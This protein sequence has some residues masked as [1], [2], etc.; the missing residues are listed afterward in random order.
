MKDLNNLISRFKGSRRI[1][2]VSVWFGLI[3]GL[4]EGI[5][6]NF[7]RQIPGFALRVPAEILW[8][9]PALNLI[10]FLVM[11]VGFSLLVGVLGRE[12]DSWL[13]LALYGC[14]TL[15]GLLMVTGKLPQSASLILSLG[16]AAEVGRRLRNHEQRL[17]GFFRRTVV[18][19]AGVALVVGTMGAQWEGWRERSLLAGLPEA[20]AGAPNLLVIVLDTLRADHLSAYGYDRLTTPNLDRLA[21]G[22]VLFE[23]A[24]A[25]TSWTLPSHASL[26]T[27]RF[28][29]EHEADWGMPLNRKYPT[30]AEALARQGYRTAAFA[31]N[32][33]YVSPE[34][35]LKRGFS[36]FEV[37]GD[38]LADDA[39]RTVYGRKAALTI[40]PRLGYFDIPGRKNAE[41]VNQEFLRWVDGRDGRP[42]FAF[43]NYNDVHDPYLTKEPFQT[44]FSNKVA[45]GDVINFQFQANAF[46]RNL[47]VTPEEAQMETNGY[48]GTLAYL[49]HQ[50][51]ALFAELAR[52]GLD[53]STLVVV[54]SDHGEAFGN[55]DLFGHGN[56]LYWE[57]LHVPL[58]FSWPGKIPANVRVSPIVSLHQIPATI[59]DLFGSTASPAFP[60]KSLAKLWSGNADNGPREPVLAEVSRKGGGL[61]HYPAAAHSLRSL[62]TDEWHF[63]LSDTGR[64][65]LYAWRADPK[66]NHD[67]VDTP[68]G[69]IVVKKLL[70]QLADMMA[71]AGVSDK[72]EAKAR[73]GE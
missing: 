11:G 37:Y 12:P 8:I 55:H 60:G 56:S 38:S 67:L 46:R 50:L 2:L 20:Q 31:A 21:Q 51:G 53:K 72:A 63:I 44:Q 40:L 65:E 24:V 7:L 64:A 30:L 39:M 13:L 66:E 4:L 62:V 16:I 22:G 48:D 29:H 41:R 34:W 70:Q 19:L 23:Y 10:L 26:F 25:N 47:I 5:V 15:F 57:T 49:D 42:F 58:I 68:E 59:M 33:S 35:G 28:P 52:R 36:R 6:A 9:A 71:A 61:P 69:R 18:P 43:L 45:R 14:V 3:S 54:T 1:L 17:R 27:G 32:T 73:I